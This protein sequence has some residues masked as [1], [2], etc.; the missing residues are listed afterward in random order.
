MSTETK[1]IELT[2]E[3]EALYARYDFLTAELRRLNLR[4]DASGK[5]VGEATP[6]ALADMFNAMAYITQVNQLLPLVWRK[7][8]ALA[9]LEGVPT[10][11]TPVMQK[12]FLH[13]N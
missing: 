10:C 2:I 4:P 8:M 13:A 9:A 7:E 12:Y 1:M 11:Q 6:A 5:V 3:I